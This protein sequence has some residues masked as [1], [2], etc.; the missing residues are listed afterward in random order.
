MKNGVAA[1]TGKEFAPM[2]IGRLT[3]AI[4]ALC[5]LT[6]GVKAQQVETPLGVVELFTSQG[7]SSCPPADAALASLAE[8]GEV[9]VLSY[10]VDYWNY[11]G[12]D[13]TLSLPECTARQKAYA[14]AFE[15]NSVYTPQ[16]VLNGRDHV[17]GAHRDLIESKIERFD[18]TGRGLKVAIEVS[19]RGDTVLIDIPAGDTSANVVLAVFDKRTSVDIANGENGGRTIVYV[20]SIRSLQPVGMWNGKAVTLTLPASVI[21]NW[22]KQG[23]AVLLQKMDGDVP[24]AIIGASYL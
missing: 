16:A 15:R 20:N 10:H 9:L 17:N 21:D 1:G 2:S 7:C 6:S 8:E 3:S 22:N 24:G 11:L 18:A 23:G 12:W 4:L 13:D 5:L 14:A 19:R